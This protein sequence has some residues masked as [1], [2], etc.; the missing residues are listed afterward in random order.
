VSVC[1][2]VTP[3]GPCALPTHSRGYHDPDPPKLRVPRNAAGHPQVSISQLRRYGAVDLATGGE[4]ATESVRGC[5]RAYALTYGVGEVPEFR[6]KAAELGILL[7]RALHHM[8]E[9]ICGPEEALGAVLTSTTGLV[10]YTEARRILDDYL[11]RGGPATMYATLAA[12]LDLTAQLYVDDVHGPVDFRGIIDHLG[13]DTADPGTV[14]VTD[15]KGL[16]VDTPLPTPSGWTTM[17]DV[18]VGDK[19]FG[20]DGMPCSVVG[21]SV[22]HWKD[23]YRIIF[24]DSTSVI[25]DGEHRWVVLAGPIGGRRKPLVPVEMTAAEIYDRGV[26]DRS[27]SHDV[28]VA[29]AQA[30]DLPEAD[31]PADPYVLGAWLGDGSTGSGRI[32]QANPRLWD[33]IQKRGYELSPEKPGSKLQVRM[34]YGLSTELKAAGVFHRKNLPDLYARASRQQR[35]DVL[36]G[37]MDTDGHW[38]TSRERAVMNTTAE[39]QADAV[40][41]L[42]VSLGWKATRMPTT[43]KGFGKTV[44]AWQVWFSPVGEHIFVAR[45]PDGYRLDNSVRRAHRAIRSIEKVPTVPTQCI[46]VDNQEQMYLA[47][48]QMIPTHNSAARPVSK[49]SLR[50]DVQLMGYTWLVREWWK[51]QH[52]TYPRRVIAHFDALRYGDVAIEY[53]RHELELWQEWAAAMVRSMLRET[54]PAPILNDGCTWCPVRWGCPAWQALPGEAQSAAARLA[55]ASPEQLGDRYVAATQVLKLLEHQ[56]TD[57]KTVLEQEA[58]ARGSLVVGGQEWVAESGTK[59][60]SNVLGLVDL[61]LPDHPGAFETAVTV[62]KASVERAAQGLEDLGLAE[63]VMGCV[64]SVKSGWRIA[65]RK[66]KKGKGKS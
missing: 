25:C 45:P 56:V 39:W 33:E 3:A 61:L 66:V 31:L 19:L 65:R 55:G 51:T 40:C 1:G 14:H 8:E 35:L 16:S 38:N 64:A 60:V 50:G 23:C 7:H 4:D 27:G 21:K 24:G 20:P 62:T 32:T 17:G 58:I 5:P 46:A 28:R 11:T 37:L 29:N 26:V 15:Y 6:S 22:V 54:Y 10:G 30:L 48:R 57:H 12:E 41:E 2:A 44:Q 36:R 53:T 18:E 47:G 42:V 52:G 49:E 34:V 59:T 9:Q 13:V 63:Q 43:A